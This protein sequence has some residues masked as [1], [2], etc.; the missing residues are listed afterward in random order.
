LDFFS[1]RPSE[2][3]EFKPLFRGGLGQGGLKLQLKW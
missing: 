1:V 3:G 2:G